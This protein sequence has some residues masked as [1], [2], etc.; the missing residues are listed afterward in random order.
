MTRACGLPLVVII[1]LT[2]SACG[3]SST[4]AAQVTV[5]QT[6]TGSSSSTST[7]A[8]SPASTTS[9]TPSIPACTAAALQLISEGTN[10]AAGTIVATF[11][12]RNG[13]GSPCHTHGYPGV[14]F[15]NRAGAA[16]PTRARRTSH[17]L[18]GSTPVTT[19]VID[20]GRLASFRI[21]APLIGSGAG[22]KTAFGLQ[23]IAPDDTATLR[24][25]IPG[26][27]LECTKVTLS[28]L[29]PGTGIP[30]GT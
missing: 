10:G 11:A 20:P 15:L 16:L 22:C 30:Q 29:A 25:T 7:S 23:V 19:F 18:L 8:T 6:V 1:A 2:V 28:P 17:D 9:T 14:L 12:L 24:T 27:L 13:S 5:T 4:P 21:V 26:G 3:G